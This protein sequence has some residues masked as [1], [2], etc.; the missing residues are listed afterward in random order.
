VS[1][2][3]MSHARIDQRLG[4]LEARIA[5]GRVAAA[6][7]RRPSSSL[8]AVGFSTACSVSL[9]VSRPV[10]LPSLSVTSSFSMRRA[11]IRLMASS[12]SAGSRRMARFSP[13][14]ITCTGVS[15]AS[16]K[17]MSRLVTIP[18][19]SRLIDHREPGETVAFGQ[20]LGVGQRLVGAS[21]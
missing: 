3:I 6:T 10:S 7:R 16:A 1:I 20:R 2:T 13:V 4:A 11:F 14:I 9:S 15:S 21:G 18:H 17:R 5:H 8:Q 19:A 12:R